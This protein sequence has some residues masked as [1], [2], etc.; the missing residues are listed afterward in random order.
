MGIDGLW[1]ILEPVR[2]TVTLQE[3]S[4][5]KG[6]LANING[7]R[8][9]HVG[10]DAS[11]IMAGYTYN[12]NA[13][14]HIHATADGPLVQ[15]WRLLNQLSRATVDATFV[16]DGE[17][18]P[19]KKRGRTVIH[20]E[21]LYQKKCKQL[22][23]AFG[24]RNHAAPGEA[25]AELCEMN[26]RGVIEA[27]VTIDSDVFPGG[28]THV[29]RINSKKSTD[30]QLV[31]DIFDAARIQET[32]GL[33]HAGLILIAGLAGN[34]LHDGLDGCGIE[35]SRQLAQAGFAEGLIQ[36]YQLSKHSSSR[37]H[38]RMD[39]LRLDIANELRTK[40]KRTEGNRNEKL[41]RH[42]LGQSE[43]IPISVLRHF[44]EPVSSWSE[45]NQQPDISRW[46]PQLHDMDAIL[47]FC[48]EHMG[49]KDDYVLKR[50]HSELYAGV[51]IRMLSSKYLGYEQATGKI[52]V[53]I[54]GKHGARQ[55]QIIGP[56]PPNLA[57]A[58]PARRLTF[59]VAGIINA[60]L[61]H[62]D[63]VM[64]TVP[65]PL[66][67]DMVNRFVHG[68]NPKVKA[69]RVNTLK[70]KA[71]KVRGSKAKASKANAAKARA[72]KKAIRRPQLKKRKNQITEIMDFTE[73]EDS[74]RVVP[75]K[76]SGEVIELTD[77]EEDV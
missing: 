6:F 54:L 43:L 61:E 35:T 72:S 57:N 62:K 8:V 19:E 65:T 74:P 18:R 33:S 70:V 4:V 39:R 22:V 68:R 69:S 10:I 73:D 41:A 34:D 14:A 12:S 16:Y 60:P 59:S 48:K 55:T 42:I 71:S 23:E 75:V 36:D 31:V 76:D 38:D 32:L 63:T 45:G 53:L 21:P 11:T 26:Q 13:H 67:T 64:V 56:N 28:A 27:I 3:Y 24:Y 37:F 2:Q 50:W 40:K 47:T 46:L 51:I 1:P 30:T 25:E 17:N 49:W 29:M 20:V 7:S 77:S 44:I 52:T 66:I 15:M 58:G 9:L 5:Q